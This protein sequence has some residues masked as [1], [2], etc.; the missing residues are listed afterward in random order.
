[1]DKVWIVVESDLGGCSCIRG[2][3][4][5]KDMALKAAQQWNDQ[6]LEE[7]SRRPLQVQVYSAFNVE[8]WFVK[9][10]SNEQ[11]NRPE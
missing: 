10:D 2:V 7:Q 1:M 11:S 5:T 4:S 3:Y 6:Q 8:E 9:G